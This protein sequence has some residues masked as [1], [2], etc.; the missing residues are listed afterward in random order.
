MSKMFFPNGLKPGDPISKKGFV[1]GILKMAKALEKLSVHGGRVDWAN[2]EPK[3]IFQNL[4]DSETVKTAV[5]PSGV[6]RR[7]RT[8]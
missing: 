1:D 3:I 7:T 8:A 2:G 4:V 6:S 5:R